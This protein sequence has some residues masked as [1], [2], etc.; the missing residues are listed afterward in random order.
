M[1]KFEFESSHLSAHL[2]NSVCSAVSYENILGPL[3][4]DARRETHISREQMDWSMVILAQS[5][6]SRLGDRLLRSLRAL[7]RMQQQT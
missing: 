1:I 4:Q 3:Q 6:S 2:H 7:D 5:A